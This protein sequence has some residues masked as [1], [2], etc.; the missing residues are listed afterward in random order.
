MS[1]NTP[2]EVKLKNVAG[3]RLD[4]DY[5]GPKDYK[6]FAR[7]FQSKINERRMRGI[8]LSSGAVEVLQKRLDGIAEELNVPLEERIILK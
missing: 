4:S 8:N 2:N 6:V 7:T 3:G 5:N 1:K